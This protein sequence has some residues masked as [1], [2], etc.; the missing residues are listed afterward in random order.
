MLTI[1]CNYGLA[2][3]MQELRNPV[4]HEKPGFW[5]LVLRGKCLT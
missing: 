2:L 5:V 1:T 4:P 3:E